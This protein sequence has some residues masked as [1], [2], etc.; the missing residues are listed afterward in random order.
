MCVPDG[1]PLY[2]C[3]LSIVVI[4]TCCNTHL[5]VARSGGSYRIQCYLHANFIREKIQAPNPNMSPNSPKWAAAV[6]LLFGMI[7]FY[8]RH[9]ITFFQ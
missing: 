2:T 4:F 9:S 1:N 5:H 6:C 7:F 3:T 8:D